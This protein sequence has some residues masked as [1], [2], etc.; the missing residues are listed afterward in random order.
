MK[1]RQCQK[2]TDNLVNDLP[3]CEECV[4]KPRYRYY[5]YLRPPGFA[6]VPDGWILR[7]FWK[8]PER[9]PGSMFTAHGWVEYAE[10]LPFGRVLKFDLIASRRGGRQ[11]YGMETGE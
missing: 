5:A 2:E 6:A 3:L 10:P 7:E 8:P 4:D 11:V 9:I 1:C